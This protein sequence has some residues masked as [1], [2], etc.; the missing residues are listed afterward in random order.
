MMKVIASSLSGLMSLSLVHVLQAK[1]VC[2]SLRR[3]NGCHHF[4][5]QKQKYD[6]EAQL[7]LTVCIWLTKAKTWEEEMG[8]KESGRL[9]LLLDHQA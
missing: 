5:R 8:S 9:K 1:H 7:S 6:T 2:L 4:I 3:R